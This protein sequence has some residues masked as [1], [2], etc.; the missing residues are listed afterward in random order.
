MLRIPIAERRDWRATALEY[1]FHFHTLYGEPYWDESAYYQFS[2]KQI[3][4][5]IEDPTAEIHQ[6]CL[7]VVDRVVRDEQ[8]LHRFQIPQRFWDLIARSWY[9]RDPSLYSR[10]DLEFRA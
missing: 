7:D 8:L 9:N 3:E 6:M 2:L 4:H 10:I 5:H 1:G